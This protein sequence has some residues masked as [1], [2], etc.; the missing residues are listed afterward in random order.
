M[1][2]LKGVLKEEQQRLKAL[3]NKYRSEIEALPRGSVSIKKRNNNEYLYLAYRQKNKV[4]FEYIGPIVSKKARAV[5]KQIE[6]RKKYET[7]MKQVK[8]DLVEIEKVMNGR[9]IPTS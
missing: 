1:S 8:Q 5:I 7:K 3:C 6:L 2:Y 4:K 9:K